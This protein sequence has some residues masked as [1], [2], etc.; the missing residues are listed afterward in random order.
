MNQRIANPTQ[1]LPGV[2]CHSE[3]L[4]LVD[5]LHH[6]Q[7][8]DERHRDVAFTVLAHNHVAGQ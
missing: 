2:F 3:H 4:R 7:R 6:H 5:Y 8:I 1:S